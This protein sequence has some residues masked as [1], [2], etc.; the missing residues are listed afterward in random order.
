MILTLS[1]PVLE[2]GG[3][4]LLQ[5]TEL[6]L[7]P[8]VVYCIGGR[9]GTGKTSFLR[10]LIGSDE[11]RVVEGTIRVAAGSGLIGV[12]GFQPQC[13]QDIVLLQQGAPLWP[14]KTAFENAWMPWALQRGVVQF[15]AR[16]A[17][18]RS[19]ASERLDQL[20]I[21]R[22]AWSRRPSRLS[23]G[24]RRRV[25]LAAALVF[26]CPCILLD[27]PTANLD[28]ASTEP[29]CAL[30]SKEAARGKMVILTSHDPDLLSQPGWIHFRVSPNDTSAI[31]EWKLVS[32][33]NRS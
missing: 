18:A 29:I 5:T 15:W 6:T 1:S 10:A 3:R 23:G 8:G 22:G 33:D 31:S 11:I 21:D 27:E 26:E 7:N 2:V 32:G 20:Q 25:A 30:L 28:R 13:G 9:S 19:R 4:R 16:R 12:N 17:E 24:E 14:Q